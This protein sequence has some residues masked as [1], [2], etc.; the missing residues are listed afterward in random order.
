MQDKK[1]AGQAFPSKQ[2]E[3]ILKGFENDKQ[4]TNVKIKNLEL[5]LTRTQKELE[6][7]KKKQDELNL[8]ILKYAADLDKWKKGPVEDPVKNPV[9]KPVENPVTFPVTPPI[10]SRN[11]F[12]VNSLI[13]TTGSTRRN[14]KENEP[15]DTAI[16]YLIPYKGNNRALLKAAR[17]YDVYC[18]GVHWNKLTGYLKAKYCRG[19]YFF[20]DVAPGRY[21]I[22]TCTVFGSFKT[23]DWTGKMV[24][25]ITIPLKLPG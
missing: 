24:K 14:L 17:N 6:D 25:P 8:L 15:F 5:E 2:Y 22:R 20:D 19:V 4:V 1:G 18:A 21:L 10:E 7:R 23:I 9:N 13:L 12:N 11:C 16:I 3:G